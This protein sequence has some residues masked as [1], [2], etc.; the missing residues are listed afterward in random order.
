VLVTGSGGYIGAVLCPALV[1][2][3]HD[4]IGLDSG[5]FEGCDFGEGPGAVPS[6]RVD[7]RDVS[8]EQLAGFDAVIHLAAL[9][10]DP[11]GELDPERTYEINHRASVRL[12]RL[13]REAGVRRFLFSSSC[14]LY[15]AADPEQ[16]LDE[17]A[18]LNPVTAYGRSKVLVERDV[19]GLAAAGFSPVFLRNA[20]VYGVS[21][22]LRAD[23]VVNNLTGHAVTTGRVLVMSD[24]TPWRPLVHVQDVAA[25]FVHLLTAP[26]DRIHGRAFNVGRTEEN[27]RV[28]DV[29]AMVRD[30]VPGSAVTYAEGAGPDPRCYRVDFGKLAETFPGLELRWTVRAGVEELRDA[31]LRWGLSAEEFL[32]PRYQ[33]LAHLR[34]LTEGGAVG[35][36]LRMRAPAETMGR[37]G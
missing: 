28:R 21:P 32:G 12:A 20:T 35:A 8:V 14:S 34:A 13:A 17:T 7:L 31:Y 36:D 3:G 16:L 11:L 2:A 22:R 10:N 19:A 1:E 15:G 18:T 29:A 37:V 4:V 5:L 33:R 23:L 25:T 27:Y 9:S 30:L 6:M 26:V 24:G